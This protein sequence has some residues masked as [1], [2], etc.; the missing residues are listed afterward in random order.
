MSRLGGKVALISGGAVGLGKACAELLANH[1][2][3][4]VIGDI[5]AANGK[6]TADA[7]CASGGV[8]TFTELDVTSESSWKD[9]VSFCEKAYGSLSILVNNAGIYVLGST[10]E[11]SVEDWDRTF[12]VN[13]RGVFLGSKT[14][15][16]LMKRGSAGS[17]INISSNFGLVGC[18]DSAAYVASKGA[19]RLLTKATASEVA[20]YGIRV[21]SVHP[22]LLATPMTQEVMK[23]AEITKRLVGPTLFKRPGTPEEVAAAVL[24]LASDEASFVTGT[25]LA[26]DG[27]YTAV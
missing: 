11:A 7:I 19:V 6:A 18:V 27:G 8:A 26:V 2:A 4:V 5:D 22:N 3:S 1:G 20:Q 14:A 21:N 17:I 24:F 15:I 13:A 10:E 9:A 12:A 25:E 23:D 16:A